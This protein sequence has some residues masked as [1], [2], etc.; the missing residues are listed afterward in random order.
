MLFQDPWNNWH[1]KVRCLIVF[2][3]VHTKNLT[4]VIDKRS[5]RTSLPKQKKNNGEKSVSIIKKKTNNLLSL[6]GPIGQHHGWWISQ[7]RFSSSLII[8]CL[9]VWW[10]G[11]S[12]ISSWNMFKRDH[13]LL[14]YRL[15]EYHSS[16][17][18]SFTKLRLQ[19]TKQ[20]RIRTMV[21]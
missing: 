14:S 2:I 8:F 10:G 19:I 4:I 15:K 7:F 20:E 16:W 1:W 3:E 12:I 21:N 6:L 18:P 17:L 11:G 9:C 5:S 13:F